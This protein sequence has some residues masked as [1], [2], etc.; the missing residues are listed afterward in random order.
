MN[1]QAH[2]PIGDLVE[3][4]SYLAHLGDDWDVFRFSDGLLWANGQGF[5]L[6][7]FERIGGRV[8]R[9]EEVDAHDAELRRLR[10]CM[11]AISIE[12]AYCADTLEE[13]TETIAIVTQMA[14]MAL[15]GDEVPTTGQLAVSV[16]SA[17]R[18]VLA[19]RK[20]QQAV[21]GWTP[22]HDD[23]YTKGQLARAACAYIYGGFMMWP[24]DFDPQMFK[25]STR[26]RDLEKGIALALAE[27][28]RI[29]RA[30]DRAAGVS[31]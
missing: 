11:S 28:E 19:E 1:F 10:S 31:A 24:E 13:A 22:E 6:G 16:R 7:K 12:T 20:R 18:D 17:A 15:D 29:D 23:Q 30:A 8:F 14:D 9:P 27:L 2:T 4:G 26:R 5:H 25:M 21:E 3:G